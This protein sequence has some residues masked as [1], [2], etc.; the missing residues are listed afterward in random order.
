MGKKN[1]KKEN[2]KVN[3]STLGLI[4]LVF[5]GVILIFDFLDFRHSHFYQDVLILFIHL[6]N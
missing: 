1:R 2:L 6:F 4:S 5:I 3:L